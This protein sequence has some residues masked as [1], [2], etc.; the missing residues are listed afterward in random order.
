VNTR[1]A[2]PKATLALRPSQVPTPVLEDSF[3]PLLFDVPESSR[4][5]LPDP[6]RHLLESVAPLP[7]DRQDSL[8][9]D[10][11][12]FRALQ[13]C[14][15]SH[16][17][18]VRVEGLTFLLADR[19]RELDEAK[20]KLGLLQGG[21][22]SNSDS[23]SDSDNDNSAEGEE[24]GHEVC[25]P[26]DP[27][28]CWTPSWMLWRRP[29]SRQLRLGL[30]WQLPWPTSPAALTP[31]LP[32]FPSSSAPSRYTFPHPPDW[33]SSCLEGSV[34]ALQLPLQQPCQRGHDLLD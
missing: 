10:P 21:G 3:P 2:S 26:I 15:P 30:S 28:S 7:Q 8:W 1:L 4:L 16:K 33:R 19:T 17:L 18:E 25:Y 23:D 11:R 32:A 20:M 27:R 9:H 6:P 12:D 22:D 13:V 34:I 29:T 24:V 31:A 5:D 14:L